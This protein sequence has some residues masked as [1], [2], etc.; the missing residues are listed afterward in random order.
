MQQVSD[1]DNISFLLSHCLTTVSADKHLP[2]K[3]LWDR[4]NNNWYGLF[5]QNCQNFAS[6]LYVAIATRIPDSE[7]SL[8]DEMPDPVIYALSKVSNYGT[9]GQIVLSSWTIGATALTA[10]EAAAIGPATALA[11][12]EGAGAAAATGIQAGGVTTTAAA[13]STSSTASATVAKGGAAG[14]GKVGIGAKLAAAGHTKA[15]AIAGKGAFMLG[16]APAIGVGTIAASVYFR[17]KYKK[18]KEARQQLMEGSWHDDIDGEDDMKDEDFT[19]EGWLEKEDFLFKEAEDGGDEV[20]KEIEDEL[21]K[22]LEMTRITSEPA[23][24]PDQ[25]LDSDSGLAARSDP[26]REQTLS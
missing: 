5:T 8:W 23:Q 6:L 22:E 20:D 15:A 2:A 14:S 1:A 19:I 17:K 21:A 9:A 3:K 16:P 18:H 25:Q 11:A 10:T 26:R 13:G 4:F 24:M 12:T 7:R